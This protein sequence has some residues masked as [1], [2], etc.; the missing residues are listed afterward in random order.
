MTE[1]QVDGISRWLTSEQMVEGS[2]RF[3]AHAKFN[4]LSEDLTPPLITALYRKKKL[5]PRPRFVKMMSPPKNFGAKTDLVYNVVI[6]L[7]N[8]NVTLENVQRYS[9]PST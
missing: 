5:P 7:I 4:G 3:V 9:T 2:A 6:H 8:T 1:G